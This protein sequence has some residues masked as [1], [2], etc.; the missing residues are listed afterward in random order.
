MPSDWDFIYETGYWPCNHFI[1]SAWI[2]LF[3]VSILWIGMHFNMRIVIAFLLAF[4]SGVC[5]EIVETLMCFWGYTFWCETAGDSKIGDLFTNT[6]GIIVMTMLVNRYSHITAV[7]IQFKTV[8]ETIVR[9]ILFFMVYALFRAGVLSVSAG[10]YTI[11]YGTIIS[12]TT[13]LFIFGA[14]FWFDLLTLSHDPDVEMQDKEKQSIVRHDVRM[15]WT[16]FIMIYV[17]VSLITLFASI[18]NFY[19]YFVL[20]PCEIIIII[21]L[22]I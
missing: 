18:L 13:T 2:M 1:G 9:L 21:I 15:F 5:V 22:L 4:I 17:V 3:W 6:L 12:I 8:I 19:T 16:W 14:F 11:P 20:L 7:F 10:G